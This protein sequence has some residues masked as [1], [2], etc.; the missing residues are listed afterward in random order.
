[1]LEYENQCVGC[2]LPCL[3]PSCKYLKVPVFYCDQC[4]EYARYRYDGE[5]YCES[6]FEKMLD[7]VFEDLTIIEKAQVW[8]VDYEDVEDLDK[9]SICD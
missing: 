7:G 4:G 3:G 6:C 2:V 9:A 5:D 8:D 1:M